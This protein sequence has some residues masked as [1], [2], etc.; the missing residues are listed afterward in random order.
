LIKVAGASVRGR[1]HERAGTPCQDRYNVWR[2]GDKK[3]AG[4]AVSDG[5]GSS[6]YS[7]I[8]AEFAAG[9]IIPY[10]AKKF[11]YSSNNLIDAQNEIFGYLSNGLMNVAKSHNLNFNDLACTLLFVVI[12][13]KRKTVNYIAGHIGDG[14]ILYQR[15]NNSINILSEPERGEFAN[16][17][18]FLTSKNAKTKL[19]IY[20]GKLEQPSGFIIMSDGAADTLYIKRTKSPNQIYC[21]QLLKWCDRYPQNKVSKALHKNLR[22]GVFR[23]VSTDDCSLCLLKV[24]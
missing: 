18:I 13:R 4:I 8:G 21:Q 14:I 12:K 15:K 11:D 2:K 9:S 20:S 7:Q 24:S 22:Y 19:R 5:A 23:E 16:T 17:T 3:F 10:I 6:G 1:S